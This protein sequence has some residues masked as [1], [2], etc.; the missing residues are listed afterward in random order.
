[1]W[2]RQYELKVGIIAVDPSPDRLQKVMMHTIP[3]RRPGNTCK[4][5]VARG[6]VRKGVQKAVCPNH[7]SITGQHASAWR[8]HDAAIPPAETNV[9]D[10]DG[11][12]NVHTW[13]KPSVKCETKPKPMHLPAPCSRPCWP[14][15][16]MRL[17]GPRRQSVRELI[18]ITWWQNAACDTQ[19]G[20]QFKQSAI[21]ATD[22]DQT[23][24]S[25]LQPLTGNGWRY[26]YIPS[27]GSTD[28]RLTITNRYT[29]LRTFG[30][31]Q[32]RE[33]LF[34]KS[35]EWYDEQ[36]DLWTRFQICDFL[37]STTWFDEKTSSRQT[38]AYLTHKKCIQCSY[39]ESGRTQVES[40]WPVC[41]PAINGRRCYHAGQPEQ[42]GKTAFR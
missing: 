5:A 6:S 8:D 34:S 38:Y 36:S 39:Q 18:W 41:Q 33:T 9:E 2:A 19:R 15:R 31:S 13:E 17:P 42:I 30:K 23:D 22:A 11:F 1:M 40:G 32:C 4:G 10:V 20:A 35:Y 27:Y 14:E 37:H 21:R 28:N 24:C 16:L 7:G 26:R 12:E 25:D 29:T 3:Y